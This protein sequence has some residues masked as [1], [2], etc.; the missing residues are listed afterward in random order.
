MLC[1]PNLRYFCTKSFAKLPTKSYFCVNCSLQGSKRANRTNTFVMKTIPYFILFSMLTISVIGCLPPEPP[2]TDVSIDFNDETQRALYDFQDKQELDSLLAYFDSENANLRY[3]AAM[4]FASYQNKA[5]LPGL[6][7]LLNDESEAVRQAA[8]YAI[9][10]IGSPESEAALIEAF[11]QEDTTGQHTEFNKTVLEAVGKSASPQYLQALATIQTYRSTDTLLL[12]G[13]AWGIYRYALRGE[14]L[15]EGTQR[16]ISYATDDTY[17]QRVRYIAANYLMRASN[18]QLDSLQV[19]ADLAQT[20]ARN[21]DARIRMA[22]AIALGKTKTQV[23]LD[24]LLNQYNIDADYRVKTNILRAFSNYTYEQVR[25]TILEA[26]RD[27]NLHIANRAVQFLVEKGEPREALDYRE[28]ARDTSLHW[29]I[30]AGMYQAAYAL[31][32]AFYTE[33]RDRLTYELRRAFEQSPDP[34]E[35]T[36]L[37]QALAENGWNYRYIGDAGLNARNPVTK[38]G[39]VSALAKIAQRPDFDRFFGAGTRRATRDIG[40]FLLATLK[41]QDAGAI[42]IAAGAL[43]TPGRAFREIYA[44]SIVVLETA[45]ASLDLPKEIETFNEVQQT[46]A[47]FKNET[48]IPAKPVFN[49]PIE[50]SYLNALNDNTRIVLETEKG[51]IT[52]RLLPKLAPGTVIN[53]IKLVE[54][55]FYDGKNFHR[56]VPNF[57]IQGGCTRGDGYGSLDYTIRSELPPAN[58]DEEGY[59]GMASAGNH[60]EGTQFF[61]THAPAPH[62]DGDYTIFAKVESGM[63]VVH[64][65]E[66]DDVITEA[67]LDNYGANEA[68]SA[69]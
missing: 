69:N 66:I 5:A 17:S 19:D 56:V 8:A 37:M 36:A 29:Q 58:Y 40:R 44:D 53:F 28:I 9:G 25:P 24:A 33:A 50:W 30:R 7:N 26:I 6:Q 65:I 21:Q 41:T 59:V 23:A 51:A 15:P 45:L 46:L 22:L 4:A 13:Q 35:K 60:T 10:Q 34:Y 38:T 3:L 27:P 52:L 55:G 42:A 39:C 16:M 54:E 1:Q 57:V 61:I 68:L 14:T 47:Y 11:H 49:N 2:S 64:Q 48:Y 62:L 43:R 12:E 32:P 18:L 63:D 20:M 67:R 31:L